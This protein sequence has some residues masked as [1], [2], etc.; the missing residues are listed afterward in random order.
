[1]VTQGGGEGA[2]LAVLLRVLLLL[3][4]VSLLV[5]LLLLVEGLGLVLLGVILALSFLG[6]SAAK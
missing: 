2:L 6:Q 3:L 1:M 4:K 5:V